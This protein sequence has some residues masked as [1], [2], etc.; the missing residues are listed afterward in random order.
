MRRTIDATLATGKV[1]MDT[2]TSKIPS[3]NRLAFKA[4]GNIPGSQVRFQT[5][6]NSSL[7]ESW[8]SKTEQ[9]KAQ[10]GSQ[11]I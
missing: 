11:L 9:T 6:F 10:G 2:E 4:L 1:L 5:Q 7:I 8:G 3:L